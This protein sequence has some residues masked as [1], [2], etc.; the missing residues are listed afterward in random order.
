MSAKFGSEARW[1]LNV[2]RSLEK[3]YLSA[4]GPYGHAGFNGDQA[5]WER[6]RRP[7]VEAITRS[8]TF[9]DVGCADGSLMESVPIWA[10][11]K[12]IEIES[13]GLELSPRLADLARRRMPDLTERVYVGN[14]A[15]WYPPHRFDF[16][17]TELVYVPYSQRRWLV[18]RLLEEFV[19][20]GGR[21]IVCCYGSRA[22]APERIN[23][24]LRG[25]EFAVAG[26]AA[27]G[28]S[29]GTT[30]TRVAWLDEHGRLE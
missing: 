20:P 11:E 10:K 5:R 3:A 2:R 6:C 27:G 22:L 16:V 17:R 24:T 19:A 1:Y 26:E 8:G 15:H 30:L 29:D 25:W 12:G 7:I 14:V 28:D 21:L 4:D 18:E 13:Y 9:L 23:E